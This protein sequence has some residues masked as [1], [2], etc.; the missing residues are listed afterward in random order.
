MTDPAFISVP[1][2]AEV[3][4]RLAAAEPIDTG[5][6]ES[7]F[8]AIMRGECTGVQ[9]AAVLTGLRARGE[10][11]DEL[12]GAVR[13]LRSAMVRVAGAPDSAVDTCGTG[14]GRVTTFNISTTAAFV[15]AGAG[16]PVA[17]H[18][19]RSFTS[20]SG[21]AD[22]LESLGV[23]LSLPA[24]R[25]SEVLR[26]VGLVFLFAPDHHPAMRHVGP[27]RRELGIPT[28]MN[29]VGPL[30][31]PAGVRRQVIGVAEAARGPL[32][33][34]ALLRLG[35]VHALVVHAE[36]GMDEISPAGPTL[37]WEVRDGEVRSWTLHPAEFGVPPVA[38]DALAGGSPVENGVRLTAIF[39]GADDQAGR[40]AVLLNAAAALHVSGR[41]ASFA[42]A[43]T[44]ARHSL[45]SG[46][47]ATVLRNLI[48][49]T[50]TFE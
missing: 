38:L 43:L 29:L 6:A 32:V 46:A 22:V 45:E 27:I 35:T 34:Q 1:P 25:A 17:K 47:A 33:A 3:L 40:W 21:S 23:R 8:G 24:E 26:E 14:G 4:R 16:V 7:V 11:A 37:V 19:N 9:I 31:N 42:E 20:R 36:A 48:G 2:I 12:A 10:T 30:A 49:A 39:N 5:L 18:G 28:L 50:R 13:A 44:A 41:T 15:V